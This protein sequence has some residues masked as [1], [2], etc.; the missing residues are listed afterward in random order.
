MVSMRSRPQDWLWSLRRTARARASAV[1]EIE[2]VDVSRCDDGHPDVDAPGTPSD[3]H[4]EVL[5][6]EQVA[7]APVA[8]TR[9]AIDFQLPARLAYAAG[10]APAARPTRKNATPAKRRWRPIK[11]EEVVEA[12]VV[13]RRHVWLAT[14]KARRVTTEAATDAPSFRLAA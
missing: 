6:S 9:I 13:A 8:P 10:R 3:Q 7:P 1:P 12:K 5:L 2:T 11:A 4:A 14:R